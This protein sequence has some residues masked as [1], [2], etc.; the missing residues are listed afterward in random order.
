VLEEIPC[1]DSDDLDEESKKVKL[2]VSRALQES[3]ELRSC[4]LSF[5][6][7]GAIF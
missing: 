3:L 1:V 7:P 6:I 4:D 5:Y 2:G